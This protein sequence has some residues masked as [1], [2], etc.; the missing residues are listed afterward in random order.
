MLSLISHEQPVAFNPKGGEKLAVKYRK[1]IDKYISNLP[2]NQKTGT[3][4]I[5]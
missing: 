3:Q 5:A 4:D 1:E 2:N